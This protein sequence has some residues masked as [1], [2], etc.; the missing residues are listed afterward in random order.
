MFKI[1]IKIFRLLDKKQKKKLF[2]LQI[3]ILI[4]S[5]AEIGSIF[6]VGAFISAV[7]NL[8]TFLNTNNGIFLNVYHYF[9]FNN[10]NEFLIIFSTFV[11]IVFFIS[12]FVSVFTTWKLAM[13]GSKIGLDISIR[14]YKYYLQKSWIF[15]TTHNSNQLVNK[16]AQETQ[17]VTSGIISHAMHMNAKVILVAFMFFA[18]LIY[19]PLI[20]I[21]GFCFFTF[22]YWALYSL[23]KKKLSQ[24]G[25]ALSKEQ[26]TRF[27]LM[28]EGF[29]GIK[30]LLLSK[31]QNFFISLFQKSSDKYAYHLGNNQVLSLVPKYALEFLAFS[32]IIF[33]IIYLLEFPEATINSNE[34]LP[35]LA[36]YGFAGFKMLPA[37]QQIYYS[38]SAIRGNISAFENISEDLYESL[39]SEGN[40]SKNKN[41]DIRKKASNETESGKN[42]LLSFSNISFSYPSMSSPSVT[43]I[44][45]Q[46]E[47][48]SIVGF[49]GPTGSGKS[50]IIDLLLGLLKPSTGRIFFNG[51]EMND[52]N[53]IK[54]QSKCA[55]V[56]QNIFLA[57]TTIKENIAFGIPHDLIDSDKI[58]YAVKASQIEEFTDCLPLKLDTK[59]GERGI[60]LSGGQRQ[61]IGIARALYN[62][63]EVLVFD[64]ATSSLDIIT[65]KLIMNA[66][67]QFSGVKTIIIIAH[68]L[69]TVKQCD[70]IYLVEK[71]KVVDKGSYQSLAKNSKLFQGISGL[72]QK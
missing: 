61:R 35:V 50:T 5:L 40:E 1:L 62:D 42:F 39:T 48:N 16:I 26:E 6:I 19:R 18:I 51:E 30:D 38:V 32:G 59:V 69:E 37:F 67:H 31:R 46:I 10:P 60:Q 68:R 4:M 3:L 52:Q 41:I 56:A 34:I 49:V 55:F 7:S 14:L 12:S 13:Y 11:F 70:C 54:W 33:L 23:L 29:G 66:I 9:N 25:E 57:D 22:S 2:L 43:S 58:S 65:E 72:S 64:E 8:N 21:I 36:V 47:K 44:N 63:A 20:S 71:G 15:H 53:V 28:G 24:N 45:F 27:K 17:R